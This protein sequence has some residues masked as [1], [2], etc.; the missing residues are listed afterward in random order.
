MTRNIILRMIRTAEL[1]DSEE[2]GAH[3]NRVGAYSVEMYEVWARKEGF[4]ED[5]IDKKRDVLRMAAM[6]HDI[7]KVGISDTILKKP[8][9]LTQEEYEVMKTHTI[10]GARLFY[11]D[12]YEPSGF[13]LVAAEVALNHHER[14][15]GKGYPGHVDPVTGRAVP[16]FEENGRPMPKKGEEIPIFGR[17]VSLSDVYD[18]LS[19]KRSYKDPWPEEKVLQEIEK[20]SGTQFDPDVVEAFFSCLDVLRSIGR[21]YENDQTT[22]FC[23]TPLLRHQ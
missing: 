10:I 13:D 1:R 4:D 2:T 20:H 11:Q 14:W 7:G 15:D 19:S 22:S 8:A 12:Q 23:L 6:V 9:R 3:V 5:Y 21:K 17:I 18:A 16:G